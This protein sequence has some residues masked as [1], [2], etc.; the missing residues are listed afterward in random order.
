MSAGLASELHGDSQRL[1]E[2]HH[3]DRAVLLGYC[4]STAYS[5]NEYRERFGRGSQPVAF[6]KADLFDLDITFA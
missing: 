1:M 2:E 4:F 6:R 5:I 3:L